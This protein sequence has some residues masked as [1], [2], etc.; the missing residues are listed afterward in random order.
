[1]SFNRINPNRSI[2][3]SKNMLGKPVIIVVFQSYQSKQINPDL[4]VVMRQLL[5]LKRFNRIN[6]NRSIPTI[7]GTEK[8]EPEKPKF[9][10]YQSKQINPDVQQ[11]QAPVA[12]QSR[13]SIVS[14]QT[15]QSRL[16]MQK[17]IVVLLTC[18]NRINPNRSIPTWKNA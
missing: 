11:M 3:T 7:L 9:Q 16:M 1:M 10:S 15:D 13:V 17:R 5:K 6:P 18:F 2:P 8:S 12:Q 4:S 14:I